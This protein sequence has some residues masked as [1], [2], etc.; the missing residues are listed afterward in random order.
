VIAVIL[1]G[2]LSRRLGGVPKG[3]LPMGGET[4]LARTVAGAARVVAPAGNPPVGTDSAAAVAVVGPAEPVANWL[5][6]WAGHALVCE[7]QEDPPFSGPAAGIAAGLAALKACEGYVLVL[8]CDMPRAGELARFLASKIPGCA[9]DQGVM[10]M[11]SGRR[12]PLAAIYP[13]A[14]LQEAVAAARA[15]HRLENASVFALVAS[16]NTKECAVAPGLTADIDTWEDARLH[17]IAAPE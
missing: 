7:V 10:A 3:G 2:G 15:A 4:L 16:V 12:Q 1:A 9:P 5:G 6:E 13:V 17:G 14:Q 8:A 11:A